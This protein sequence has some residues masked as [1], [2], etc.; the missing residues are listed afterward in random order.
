MQDAMEKAKLLPKD[1][2]VIKAHATGTLQ[3]DRAEAEALN[4]VFPLHP[5]VTALKPY[6]G[7]TMGACGTNELVLLM[8]SLKQNFIP[9]ALNFSNIEDTHPLKPMDINIP[10]IHGYCLLN[11][12]GFGGNNCCLIIKYRGK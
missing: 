10:A 1:I 12:L 9:K 2:S 3:N 11:Y 8:E 4:T 7:H 6:M 5:N